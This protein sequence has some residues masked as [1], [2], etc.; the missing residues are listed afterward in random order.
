MWGKLIIVKQKFSPK[1]SE[2]FLF[3]KNFEFRVIFIYVLAS[4]TQNFWSKLPLCGNSSVGRA[5]DFGSS[6]PGSNP[7]GA[8][9]FFLHIFAFLAYFCFT[10]MG[11]YH[12]FSLDNIFL[13]TFFHALCLVTQMVFFKKVSGILPQGAKHL[14]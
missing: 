5:S 7:G 9:F 4:N 8:T 13:A 14:L 6:D 11:I 2:N 10:N 3:S 12:L 1:W